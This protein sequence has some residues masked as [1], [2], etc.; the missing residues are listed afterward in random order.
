MRTGRDRARD[1]GLPGAG[2][3][4]R[5]CAVLCGA[6][7][8]VLTACLPPP[9]PAAQAT[10][11]GPRYV[12]L[13]DSWVSGPLVPDMVGTPIDCAR[14][15]RNAASL[16]AAELGIERFVDASCGG[17]KIEHLTEPQ[18]PAL[19]GLLGVAPPQLDAL[20]RDTTLVTIGI[21]GNDVKFPGTAI[22]CANLVPVPLG[23]PPFGRPCREE[24]TAGGRDVLAERIDEQRPRVRRALREVRRR[25]PRAQVLVIGYPT[26]LPQEGPGCWPRV[27]LLEPDV[28]YLRERFEDMNEMLRAAARAS[29]AT[30]VDTYTSSVGHDVCQ[31]P[32]TAWVNG[33][34]FDPPAAPMHPNELSFRHTAA[35][36]VDAVR[37]AR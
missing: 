1:G 8:A 2:P 36:I 31:P 12:S 5:R 33:L 25:A 19:R 34:T 37:A 30:F 32:G 17:A 14:S 10:A 24:L 23:P 28:E 22:E 18:K 27:P 21:A 26:A 11:T 35:L 20:T 3:S 15:S 4:V 6:L 13:G 7:L 29:G 16:V 9:P